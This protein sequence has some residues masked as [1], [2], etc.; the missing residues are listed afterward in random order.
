MPIIHLIR[1][2]VACGRNSDGK[3]NALYGRK[4]YGSIRNIRIGRLPLCRKHIQSVRLIIFIS[5]CKYKSILPGFGIIPVNRRLPY[6]RIVQDYEGSIIN[7][8]VRLILVFAIA[9]RLFRE[10]VDCNGIIT[11]ACPLRI[12]DEVTRRS[13]CVGKSDDRTAQCRRCIKT[14]NALLGYAVFGISCL[15]QPV[16][17]E[18][19]AVCCRIGRIVI[20]GIEHIARDPVD[21]Y[22]TGNTDRHAHR[23]EQRDLV[24]VFAHYIAVRRHRVTHIHGCSS[25]AVQSKII[26]IVFVRNKFDRVIAVS[27]RDTKTGKSAERNFL[28]ISELERRSGCAVDSDGADNHEYFLPGKIAARKRN[29]VYPRIVDGISTRAG[30]KFSVF[31]FNAISEAVKPVKGYRGC[32]INAFPYDIESGNIV[33]AGFIIIGECS[34]LVQPALK[35]DLIIAIKRKLIAVEIVSAEIYA[36]P[37][38]IDKRIFFTE[39]VDEVVAAVHI[40]ITLAPDGKQHHIPFGEESDGFR[41]RGVFF[42]INERIYIIQR[43][44]GIPVF[45]CRPPRKEITLTGKIGRQC[46]GFA[47]NDADS[48]G[49][50]RSGLCVIRIIGIKGYLIFFS[51]K[52]QFEYVLRRILFQLDRNDLVG[53]AHLTEPL[54]RQLGRNRIPDIIIISVSGNG[55]R[56]IITVERELLFVNFD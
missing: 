41:D 6:R 1:G 36:A 44:I 43:I 14:I 16:E 46:N 54:P 9:D 4:I 24:A 19:T 55:F 17:H 10:G 33:P 47:V 42:I 22:D 20:L 40:R 18:R 51:V 2:T 29:G 28:L 38:Q 39:M 34:V 53:M 50:F 27:I 37:L 35:H 32:F 21:L 15:I 30:R 25:E 23:I 31:P 11:C 3:H 56:Q 26:N 52:V 8:I 7:R 13:V 5:A 48:S 45:R 49:P 12:D